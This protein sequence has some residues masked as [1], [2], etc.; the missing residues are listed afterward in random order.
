MAVDSRSVGYWIASGIVWGALG[1]TLR[2][3][4][5]PPRH[6]MRWVVCATLFFVAATNSLAA[7]A[8]ITVVNRLTGVTNFAALLVYLL[9]VSLSASAQLLVVYWRGPVEQAWRAA[10]WWLLAYGLTDIAMIVLF[11]VGKTPVERRVDFDTYY[12]TTPFVAEFVLIYLVAQATAMGNIAWMSWRWAAVAGRP[13]LRRGLRVL[14]TGAALGFVFD[15]CKLVAVVGR[16]AG[17]DLE[18]LNSTVAPALAS[19]ATVIGTV[20]FILPMSG[21]R[22]TSVWGWVGRARAYRELYPLWNAL[23]QAT[24]TILNG[25]VPLP[26]WESQLH[27]TQRIGQIHDGRLALR[28]FVNPEVAR[29]ALRLG[30]Q[31]GLA[32]ADLDATIDAARLKA[33]IAAKAKNTKFPPETTPDPKQTPGGIDGVGEVDRLTKISQAFAKSPLVTEALDAVSTS[34]DQALPKVE[35]T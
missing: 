15:I 24:P 1:Y 12:A 7:P 25:S 30:R 33:A 18:F 13:W 32:G 14:V 28:S 4:L 34:Q 21:Y 9:V 16:A 19:P 20:G 10:R 29:H 17:A 5:R 8:A 2:D 22:L 23:R 3:L 6:P 27:L 35:I 26:W 11:V 31:A